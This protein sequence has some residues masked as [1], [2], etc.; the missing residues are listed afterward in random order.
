MLKEIIADKN[1]VWGQELEKDTDKFL[2]DLNDE[3]I[4]EIRSKK[5][6]IHNENEMDFPILT[7]QIKIFKHDILINGC[8]FFVINGSKF[9]EFSHDEMKSILKIVSKIIGELLEQNKDHEKLVEI[10]DLGKTMNGGARYHHTKEAG[11][12]HTDGCHIYH[13]FPH[14][15]GLLCINQAKSGGESKFA[16]SYTIHNQLLEQKNLLKILYEKFHIDRRNEHEINEPLTQY[17]P[18]FE[19]ENNNLVFRYQREL[20]EA[21]HKKM[22]QHL[23]DAQKDALNALDRVLANEDFIVTYLLNPYDMMFSNNKWLIHDRNNFEDFDEEN[24]KR[25]LL[26]TWIRELK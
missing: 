17:E 1:K 16:S 21:G 12:Y 24:K 22:N 7:N 18:I 9:N 19:Y 11:S 2:V 8:G 13:D 14:Y 5:M 15:I 20:V 3:V 25:S 4:N 23:T 10:K 6:E 26:R